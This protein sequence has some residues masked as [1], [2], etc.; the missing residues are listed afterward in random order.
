MLEG[1]I[2]RLGEGKVA[3]P[4]QS[5]LHQALRALQQGDQAALRRP[6]SRERRLVAEAHRMAFEFGMIGGLLNFQGQ[7]PKG[8]IN[9]LRRSYGGVLDPASEQ[10][11]QARDAQFELW[12]GSW[13]GMGGRPA[14]SEEPD[15]I[16]PFWFRWYGVAAKRVR[17]RSKILTRVKEASEQICRNRDRGFVAVS[18]DNY[19]HRR[20]RAAGGSAAGERL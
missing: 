19:G 8:L 11:A 17:S 5:R 3:P 13:F 12:L 14:R 6:G 10:G 18:L 2:T 9:T 1:A 20:G 4:R 7:L 16:V 15:L